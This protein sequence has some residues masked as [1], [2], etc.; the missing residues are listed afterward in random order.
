MA[1]LK[2]L[3][4]LVWSLK[5]DQLFNTGVVGSTSNLQQ[6][7]IELRKS[8]AQLQGN[9]N[10]QEATSNFYQSLLTAHAVS[11]ITDDELQQCESWLE[12]S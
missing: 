5:G 7:L 3:G 12:E 8:F 6:Q 9:P 2:A 1:N 10:N 4:G 11:L